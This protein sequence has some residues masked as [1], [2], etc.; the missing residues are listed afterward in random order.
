MVVRRSV[1]M[2][3][4]MVAAGISV[5]GLARAAEPDDLSRWTAIR[6][7][8]FGDK[9]IGDGASLIA[10]DTPK[11]AEDAA[12]VPIT[13]RALV[14]QTKDSYI[15]KM[16][17]II[18]ENPSPVVAKFS[19]T[20]ANGNAT[21]ATRVRVNDYTN[22]RVIAETS[23]GNLVMVSN[24]VK[25]A[26]GCSAPAGK[27]QKAAMAR[28]GKMKLVQ[29]EQVIAGQPATFQLLISHPNNSGLQ[30]DQMTRNYVP[31]HYLTSIEV[32]FNGQPALSVV[33]NISISEDPSI[34]FSYIVDKPG[35][36][37]VIAKDNRDNVFTGTFPVVTAPG[38]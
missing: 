28:M 37:K 24:Y 1:M 35:E 11:R 36:M 17:L 30:F 38:S 32:S 23:D 16:T 5:A 13:L 22:I 21:I 18:D 31:A 7:Q 15:A 20:P 33:P 10:L 14:P 25:A 29:P 12:V 8:V 34:H 19:M 9:P 27:D 6:Q 2:G 26:G 3:F 4:V